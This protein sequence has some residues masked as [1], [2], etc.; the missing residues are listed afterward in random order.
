VE[1]GFQVVGSVVLSDVIIAEVL[2]ELIPVQDHAE[3]NDTSEEGLASSP[4]YFF[5]HISRVVV[6]SEDES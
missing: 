2:G 1:V 6:G 4:E 3:F 5:I